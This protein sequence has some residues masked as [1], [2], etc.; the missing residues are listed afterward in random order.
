MSALYAVLSSIAYGAA[1][2]LGGVASRKHSAMEVVVTSQM[3]GSVFVV[4]LLTIF[5]PAQ[6]TLA[7]FL[8]GAAAGLVGGI[9]LIFFY[10][11]LATGRMAV[12]APL[13]AATTA[14]VPLVYG[15]IVGERPSSLAWVG[16]VLAIGSILL[17]TYERTPHVDEET[18]H[19]GAL[20]GFIAGIGF[21]GFFIFISQ[22]DPTS[23]VWPLVGA[24]TASIVFVF[25]LAAAL[26]R[27]VRPTKVIDRI[28]AASGFLDITANALYLAAV[29][30]GLISLASVVTSLYP[31]ATILLARVVLK[32]ELTAVRLAGVLM[33]LAGIGLIAAG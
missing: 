29:R 10:R 26:G 4:S 30:I 20:D 5:G 21:G 19:T 8:W 15:L 18:A 25:T 31:A 2:F 24:R 6:Y 27:R 14:F 22:T 33:A 23:G 1:D 16:V 17:I 3:V 12:A 28:V 32:E 13:S 9:G 7:D 11:G